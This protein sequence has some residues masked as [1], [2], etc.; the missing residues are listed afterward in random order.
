MTFVSRQNPS[1]SANSLE[2]T[3]SSVKKLKLTGAQY[4]ITFFQLHTPRRK[5]KRSQS[6]I[7]N[8]HKKALK[9][10]YTNDHS[11]RPMPIRCIF[12]PVHEHGQCTAQPLSQWSI[13][14][15]FR[16]CIRYLIPVH[17]IFTILYF[18]IPV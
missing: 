18:F 16:K 7:C 17:A 13:C 10:I 3:V 6:P 12:N 11:H 14:C 8:N 4:S 1:G 9:I 15:R 5:C 2:A